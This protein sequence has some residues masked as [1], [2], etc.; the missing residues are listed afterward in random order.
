MMSFSIKGA[1]KT[2]FVTPIILYIFVTK[3][4]AE[5]ESAL[6]FVE[7]HIRI[8]FIHEFPATQ[9]VRI[10]S[11]CPFTV[12]MRQM[13]LQMISDNHTHGASLLSHFHQQAL[14]PPTQ[15]RYIPIRSQRPTVP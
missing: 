7:V 14:S 15:C 11:R 6:K 5:D 9:N 10:K 1:T 8:W 3:E 12:M 2:F 13:H 4:E